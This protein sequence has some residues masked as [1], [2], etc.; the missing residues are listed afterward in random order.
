MKNVRIKSQNR[1]CF[2][3]DRRV[4]YFDVIADSD[5]FGYNEILSVFFREERGRKLDK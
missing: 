5:R 4:E 2:V 1:Y 3:G